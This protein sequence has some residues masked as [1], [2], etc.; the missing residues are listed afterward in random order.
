[1]P[2]K[3]LLQ[4]KLGKAGDV[5]FCNN[6]AKNVGIASAMARL[7]NAVSVQNNKPE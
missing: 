3:A 2:C 1:M 6:K 5:I 4:N 7:F